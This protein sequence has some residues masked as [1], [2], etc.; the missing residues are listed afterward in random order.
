M[1]WSCS[2]S[3]LGRKPDL[4]RR[5]R[6][7]VEFELVAAYRKT[8]GANPACQF[9]GDFEVTAEESP[10]GSTIHLLPVHQSSESAANDRVLKFEALKAEDSGNA[11]SHGVS[12]KTVP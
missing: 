11:Q 6:K 8:M 3:V 12:S 1:F 10:K 5:N 9:A 7:G 4:D 2:R